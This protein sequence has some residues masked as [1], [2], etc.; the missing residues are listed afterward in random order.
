MTANIEYSSIPSTFSKNP[1]L[2]PLLSLP[3]CP[4]PHHYPNLFLPFPKKKPPPSSP[5]NPPLLSTPSRPKTSL[6]EFTEYILELATGVEKGRGKGKRVWVM[7]GADG[8][9]EGEGE[10]EGERE[11]V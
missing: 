10:V 11:E 4:E 6:I 2:S 3:F 1:I 5:K 8:G 9:R 7:L